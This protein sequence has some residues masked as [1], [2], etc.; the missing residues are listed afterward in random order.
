MRLLLFLCIT[1]FKGLNLSAQIEGDNIFAE[2]QVI[3][4]ELE[5]LQPGFYDSL[6]ANYATSTYMK[7]NL[8]LTDSTGTT[9]FT[10]V[11]VRLKGNSSYSHPGT[12]KSFKIDFNK[13]VSGQKYDGLKKLNFSNGYKDPSLIR[14]KIFFDVSREF[15][16]P[17]PRANFANVYMNGT[18]WGFYT[19]IEQIDDQFL[20]WRILDDDGNLFKAGS[21]FGGGPGGGGDEADLLY[22]GEDQSEYEDLYELKSNEDENDWSDLI[23]FTNFITNSSDTEFDE[24]LVNHLEVDEYIKSAAMD[25]VFSNL[26]S[27]TNSARNYYVYHNLTSEKWEWIKWDGNES[28]GTYRG[29]GGPG[30]Q[31]DLTMLDI[32]YFADNRPLLERM[33]TSEVYYPQYEEQIC[34]LAAD[35]LEPLAMEARIDGIRLLIEESVFADNNKQYSNQNFTDNL[36]NNITTGGGPGGGTVYGLNSF[37]VAKKSFI[38]NQLDCAVINS[39]TQVIESEITVFPNPFQDELFVK[40]EE[41]KI[42]TI[43]IYNML[44]QEINSSWVQNGSMISIEV[45]ENYTGLLVLNVFN[46]EGKVFSQVV[47]KM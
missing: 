41:G 29:M 21:N 39:T 32:N 26:D 24:E 37:A 10:D 9:T 31:Q 14:E 35:Y 38:E 30:G 25:N 44:G 18:L 2:D 28:F 45:E 3:T 15:G 1:L 46:E 19:V 11:G 20:D 34:K 40:V 22:Y 13:Y 16:V 43:S 42:A 6:V 33:I 8:T 4:I 36:Y 12:K 47:K 23:D 5:F 27:Y 17:A 7:A